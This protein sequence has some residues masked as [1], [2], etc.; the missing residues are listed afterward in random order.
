[1]AS[2]IEWTGETWNPFVGCSLKSPGCTHCY[3]M[4]QAA[5]IQR[6]TPGSHYIGT[7]RNVKGIPV[8][9]GTINR[10][11]EHIRLAPLHRKTP[12]TWFINSMSDL[13]HEDVPDAWRDEVFAVMALCPQHIFQP[14]TKRSDIMR[15][16]MSAPERS[17]K[18]ANAIMKLV[19]DGKINWRITDDNFPFDEEAPEEE[20][21]L[22]CWPLPNVHLGVSCEDQTRAEERIPDLLATPAA[23][24]FVSAEPL[25]GPIDFRHMPFANPN[26]PSRQNVLTGEVEWGDGD[27]DFGN[28]K[29]DWVIV[30]GESGKKARPMHPD[31]ARDIRDQ[32]KADGTAFFF[33]QWGEWAPGENCNHVVTRT[34]RTA[35]LFGN[36]WQ[37]ESLTPRMLEEQHIDDAPDLYRIGKKRAGRHLDGVIHDAMPKVL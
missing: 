22:N 26:T 34:E 8:W 28:A 11:A 19:I 2:K 23:V 7:T 5:R 32:C 15:E 10:A 12:S 29:L 33:K 36:E 17:N 20:P 25:L 16:Y 31:W 3:A 37:F 14:L 13:F 1:M 9:T 6:M 27:S 4:K 24:R 30:G 18:I 21:L 35:L